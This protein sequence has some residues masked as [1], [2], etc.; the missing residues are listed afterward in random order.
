MVLKA[1]TESGKGCSILIMQNL[2]SV[3]PRAVGCFLSWHLVWTGR[4]PRSGGVHWGCLRE[5]E[6]SINRTNQAQWCEIRAA[7]KASWQHQNSELKTKSK[8]LVAQFQ[9]IYFVASGY[10]FV[11]FSSVNWIT[12]NCTVITQ[13]PSSDNVAFLILCRNAESIN[14]LQ[15]RLFFL[16]SRILASHYRHH[17]CCHTELSCLLNTGRG[18]L[19]SINSSADKV[20]S[21]LSESENKPNFLTGEQACL[22]SIPDFLSGVFRR[23]QVPC[24]YLLICLSEL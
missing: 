13:A 8:Q 5:R 22:C 24:W 3:H 21:L 23:H 10:S 18:K 20:C 11:H 7:I 19:F 17:W 6:K 15:M 9:D 16:I 12:A 4:T 2:R 1:T 14:Y